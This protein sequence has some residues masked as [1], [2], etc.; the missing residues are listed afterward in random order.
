MRAVR[1][2]RIYEPPAVRDGARILVD[3]LWPRGIS[4]QSAQLTLWLKDIAPSTVLRQWFGHEPQR[5]NEFRR[6]YRAELKA[7]ADP[8]ESLRARL[9]SSAVTLL[10]AAHD[11]EHNHARV[12]MEYLNDTG[13]PR[14]RA[15]RAPRRRTERSGKSP[16]RAKVS[17]PS[18]PG[19]RR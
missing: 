9:R 16:T 14:T 13:R 15:L 2:K 18:R 17:R 4:K 3:R 8:V 7:N 1:I 6:R 12:L 5:W 10:Y 11:P 19:A